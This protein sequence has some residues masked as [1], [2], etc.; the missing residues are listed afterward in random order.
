MSKYKCNIS[1]NCEKCP[2]R[3]S[4]PSRR[5]FVVDPDGHYIDD[6]W[7]CKFHM[8]AQMVRS[9]YLKSIEAYRDTMDDVLKRNEEMA[10]H[11]DSLERQLNEKVRK[12]M[13]P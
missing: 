6:S 3:V 1:D 2:N 8:E 4:I 10:K 12:E 5:P 7:E 11:I 13:K 9:E